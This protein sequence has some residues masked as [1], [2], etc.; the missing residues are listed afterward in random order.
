MNDKEANRLIDE[1]NQR[2][3]GKGKSI[4]DRSFIFDP[5]GKFES[6]A[7]EVLQELILN[8]TPEDKSVKYT[9]KIYDGWGDDPAKYIGIVQKDSNKN[10]FGFKNKKDIVFVRVADY[11]NSKFKIQISCFDSSLENKVVSKFEDLN[12]REFNCNGIHVWRHGYNR[13]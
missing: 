11:Y 5:K 1:Y 7:K 2:K 3:S 6:E 9:L 13:R 12:K 8:I 10:F 4:L